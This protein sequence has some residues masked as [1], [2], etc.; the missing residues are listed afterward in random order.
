ME[1]DGTRHDNA[2]QAHDYCARFQEHALE[3]PSR[4]VQKPPD[5]VHP[6]EHRLLLFVEIE[7]PQLAEITPHVLPEISPT[8]ILAQRSAEA[9]L[10]GGLWGC[11]HRLFMKI[12]TLQN[13][14]RRLRSSPWFG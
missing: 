12:L 6:L 2:P 9:G 7:F 8:D 5:G 3:Q 10:I 13:T 11:R 1:G 14:E 4:R